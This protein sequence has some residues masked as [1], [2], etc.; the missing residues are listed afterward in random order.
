MIS[1]CLLLRSGQCSCL[2][3][4]GQR[5]LYPLRPLIFAL[6]CSLYVFLDEGIVRADGG[7][8]LRLMTQWRMCD[9]WIVCGLWVCVFHQHLMVRE[10]QIVRQKQTQLQEAWQNEGVI[11]Q[12]PKLEGVYICIVFS[13]TCDTLI[14]EQ[15][16][17]DKPISLSVSFRFIAGIRTLKTQPH[18]LNLNT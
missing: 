7:W 3:Q 17:C 10:Y 1:S 16:M 9:E 18:S 12:W 4:S 2:L 8:L 15:P 13:L 6:W 11:F 14:Y 5:P